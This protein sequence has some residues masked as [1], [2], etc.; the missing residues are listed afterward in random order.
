ME[1]IIP[2]NKPRG[3][4][5]HDVVF[6]LRKIFKTKKIGHTGT[7][8][9]EVDGVLPICVGK[10]TRVADYV[11]NSGK[12]YIAEVTLGVQTTTEDAHGEIVHSVPVLN[13][14]YDEASIDAVLLQLTGVIDQTPPMY[15]AVKVNGRKLYEYARNGETIERPSRK[16]EIYEIR[17]LSDITF[18]DEVCKFK[19]EVSCSKGTYI[20]TL[21]TQIADALGT[22][23]HMSDLTRIAS[24]GFKLEES[25]TLETLQNTEYESLGELLLPI[26]HGLQHLHRVEVDENIAQKILWGQK[27]KQMSP[28]IEEETAMFYND[29]VLA[30]YMPDEK[31]PGLIKARKVFN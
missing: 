23:G 27:L 4:T 18:V 7:L 19:I 31:H 10:A 2:V 8:D 25:F 13:N 28:K 11:M 29:K 3:M 14:A 15:S 26:E 1:G 5:S 17:R 22:I 9:P 30:I 24:G 12:T 6:K 21:A 16:V 20:R